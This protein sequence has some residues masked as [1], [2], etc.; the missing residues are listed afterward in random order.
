M[1]VVSG[2]L[3]N[4]RVHFEA[5]GAERLDGEMKAFLV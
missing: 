1:Q 2:P 3:G 4:E 5:P